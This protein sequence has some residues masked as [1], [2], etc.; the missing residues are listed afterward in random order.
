M[1]TSI[2]SDSEKARF[3]MIEQQIR[4]A[5]VLD[6]R[7]LEVI[8]NTPREAFVSPSYRELAFSDLNVPLP[9]GQLMMKPIMEAR[10]LQALD[11]QPADSILEIGTGS[12][13]FT[14]LLAKLGDKVQSVEIDAAIMASAQ[15]KLDTQGIDNV[16][17]IHGDA[18]RGWDQS[19]PFDV[20]AITGSL[21]ILPDSFQQQL[22]IGGRMVAIVGQ[23]PVMQ[24]QL[25]TRI[26]DT[27][28]STE[29]LYETDFPALINAEQ[30]QAFVF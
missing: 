5:E 16:T 17:L 7:V 2:T 15:E 11:I 27:Q 26:D 24:V 28:F 12:G 22:T 23:S 19:G 29:C 20:I 25:I 10:L 14:A 30:P 13:Y 8:A 18:A 1:T 3:N 4:P 6:Q 21:P 9:N